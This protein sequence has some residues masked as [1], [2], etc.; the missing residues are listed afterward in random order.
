M[1]HGQ[2]AA[3]KVHEREDSGGE[4][5]Q[6]EIHTQKTKGQVTCPRSRFWQRADLGLSEPEPWSHVHVLTL[7]GKGCLREG[8]PTL[9]WKRGEKG[10]K[11]ASGSQL[12]PHQ[13]LF[14]VTQPTCDWSPTLDALCRYRCISP[15]PDFTIINCGFFPCHQLFSSPLKST[16]QKGRGV[17]DHKAVFRWG[18]LP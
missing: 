10:G 18:C 4:T 14:P 17:T 13:T 2:T 12:A 11:T 9:L 16:C 6:N 1:C 7:S 3:E 8:C 15:L 5:T